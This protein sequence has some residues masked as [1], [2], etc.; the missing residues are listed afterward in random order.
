MSE[1]APEAPTSPVLPVTLEGRFVRLE[2][3]TEDHSAG[4]AALHADAGAK[5][6]RNSPFPGS[7]DDYID[8]ALAALK[9]DAHLPFVVREQGT[10]AYIGM[11]RLFD[12]SPADRGLEIG[13]TWYHP[14]F[15]GG[16]TN[17]ECKLLLMTHAFEICGFERVQLKTDGRNLHSQAA[18]TK[19]GATRE[20]T[21]RHHRVRSDGLWR[22]SVY[23]SVLS[24]EWPAVKAGLEARLQR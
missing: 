15:W 11:S 13:F 6:F 20:G 19:M 21:L 9:P 7:F 1:I 17:P 12:I 14:N 10:D 2:P 8:A 4:L 24:E 5:I 3:I 23:F 22:D 18:M 16:P